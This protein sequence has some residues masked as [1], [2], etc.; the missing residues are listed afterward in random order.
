VRSSRD[1][2]EPSSRSGV[3]Q[4]IGDAATYPARVAA[5]AL[6]GQLETAAEDVLAAPEVARLLDRALSGP[7]PEEFVQSL[8][9]HRVVER[10]VQELAETGEL[11][12]L[13]DRML[14]SPRSLEFFDRVLASEEMRRALERALSGPELRAALAS[15]SAGLAEQVADGLRHAVGRLDQRLG[16][17]SAATPEALAGVASRGVALVID[18][19]LVAAGTLILGVGAEFVAWLASGL[20]PHWL[21]GML[22]G[23]VTWVVVAVYFTVFWSTTGQTPGMRAMRVRV[24]T[25]RPDRHLTPERA[26]LRTFGLVLAIVPCFLGFVPALFDR[27]RRALQDYFAHTVVV[28]DD[29]APA[30]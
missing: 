7:L 6:R 5:H 8:V 11:D 21:A 20:R 30:P 26:L 3:G 17:P 29:G 2:R 23:I 28:V 10:A 15:Q 14:A 22:A 1:E 27:R 9:R 24:H 18:A 12:R 16:R 19:V 13:L 4:A 25:D